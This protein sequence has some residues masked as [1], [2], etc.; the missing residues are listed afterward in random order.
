MSSDFV[1]VLLS[2]IIQL[3][4]AARFMGHSNMITLKLTNDIIYAFFYKFK[5]NGTMA[6][7][8]REGLLILDK[9]KFFF[10]KSGQEN[11]KRDK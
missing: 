2:L 4:K 7:S 11:R 3:Y 6:E 5:I 9:V 8:V 1:M 10:V